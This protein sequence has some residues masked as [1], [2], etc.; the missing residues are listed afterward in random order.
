MTILWSEVAPAAGSSTKPSDFDASDPNT[1][2]AGVWRRYDTL[3]TLAARHRMG[4]QF[5]LTAPGPLWAMARNSPTSRAANHWSPDPTEFGRFVY[6]VGK[7]YSGDTPGVPRVHDWSIWN[8][9]NQPGW[10]APQWQGKTQVSPR[11]YRDYVRAG[12]LALGLSGHDVQRDRILIGELAPEGSESRGFYT[13]M[14]PI[15]FLR[16]LYCLDS[17]YQPLRGGAATALGC[18]SSGARSAFVRSNPGLFQA[19]G[20]AH[21]PYNF[22]HPPRARLSDPNFVPLA[23]L[24]RLERWL[25]SA[26]RSYGAGRR[27]PI[28]LTEYGYQTKPP[29]PY[30]KVSP[31]QQ[32]AYLNEADY[33]AWRDSRVQTVSQF[34]LYDAAPDPRFSRSDFN[35]WDTFQTGLLFQSG[36][37]KPA[38][39]A[40]RMPIWIPRSSVRHGSRVL[41]WGQLRPA[42]DGSSQSATI[43]WSSGRGSFRTLAHMR[44]ANHAGYFTAQVRPPGSGRI[45]IAWRSRGGVLFSRS[46]PVSVR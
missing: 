41:V 14:T 27:L 40:Y 6:A 26:L 33:L 37:K 12:F 4:V 13:P 28:Y 15:P 23:S 36:R 42:S 31:A 1:Y 10:L 34:L 25:D 43:Q 24:G 3:L 30:Q 9:P 5:D 19:S 2:P 7:R 39:N 21:H 44:T 32:A 17:A 20:F 11:L 8:E 29:D 35:Y 16:A 38:F 45:R 18:P 22:F 46:A